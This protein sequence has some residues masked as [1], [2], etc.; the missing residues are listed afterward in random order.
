MAAW[1]RRALELFPE[2]KNELNQRDYSI[3]RLFGDLRR[4]VWRAHD[5]GD[6]AMLSAVY[7]YAAWCLGQRSGELWNAAGVSFYEHLFDERKDRADWAKVAP[8]LSA[9][10]VRSVWGLWEWRLTPDEMRD[11][12]KLFRKRTI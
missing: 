3:Y 12:A 7:G 10:V 8:W 2:L 4:I 1:R 5:A 6:D 9:Q 11:L